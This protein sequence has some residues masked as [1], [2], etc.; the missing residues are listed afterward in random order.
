VHWEE[1]LTHAFLVNAYNGFEC[2][3]SLL[4]TVSIRV[5]IRNFRD[6]PLFTVVSSHKSCPYAR[7]TSAANT[8]CKYIDVFRK[9][10]ITV[11]HILK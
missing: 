1:P 5:P 10:L 9:L 11:Y 7:C 3:P 2:C 8:V 6:F 4:E